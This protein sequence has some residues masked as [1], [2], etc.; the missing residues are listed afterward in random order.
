RGNH[1]TACKCPNP[2]YTRPVGYKP[3]PG[4]LGRAQ[5]N[6]VIKDRNTGQWSFRRRPSRSP[7]FVFMR[8][9]VG[10]Q[11]GFRPE[12]SALLDALFV[13]MLDTV[14][15]SNSIVTINLTKLSERL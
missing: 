3:L 14:N 5:R 8:P 13:V 6:L 7:Y 12:R 15:L 2:F 1:S 9:V 11:R 10:R 4:E